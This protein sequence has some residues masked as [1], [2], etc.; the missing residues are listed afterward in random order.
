MLFGDVLETDWILTPEG[1][2]NAILTTALTVES[3]PLAY[4]VA[5]NALALAQTALRPPATNDLAGAV[6][7]AQSAHGLSE[8]GGFAGGSGAYATYGGAVGDGAY[9]TDG[10]A[11]GYYAYA[12]DGGAVGNSAY[13]QS[14]GAVGFDAMTS[15]GFAGG[16]MAMA[17]LDN[18]GYGTA[19]DAIQLGTGWN[20]DPNT[21]QIYGYKLMNADGSIP[22]ERMAATLSAYAAYQ[23]SS[24]MAAASPTTTVSFAEA[25]VVIVTVSTNTVVAVDFSAADYAKGF[26]VMQVWLDYPALG[27]VVTLASGNLEYVGDEPD[28]TVTTA[29]TRQYLSFMGVGVGRKILCSKWHQT[30]GE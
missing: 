2:T 30:E 29:G 5:T 21:L 22:A 19:I 16:Y 23:A 7:H 17:A 11:V 26:P 4:P 13:A 1:V 15:S 28:L 20:P 25:A 24:A 10:G 8:N 9:A 18:T 3:D 27:P 14:G 12:V 6:A